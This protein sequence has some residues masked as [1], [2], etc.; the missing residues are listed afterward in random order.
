MRRF[1]WILAAGIDLALIALFAA[2][3]M[4]NHH[5]AILPGLVIVA[6]P[7]VA[8]AAIGWLVSLAWRAPAKPVRSGLA[9][10][11]LAVVAGMVLRV[12]T[13]GGFAWSFLIVTALVLGAFL[14]GWRAIVALVVRIRASDRP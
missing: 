3:G 9:I 6:W 13:G 14:V 2:V 11:I 4:A 12:V 10:W 7:F 8:G 1:P 5:G